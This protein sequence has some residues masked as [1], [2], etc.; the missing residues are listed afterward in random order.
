MSEQPIHPESWQLTPADAAAI[1][2]LVEAGFD[3]RRVGADVQPRALHASGLFS[4]LDA[5]RVDRGIVD[6]TL[7]RLVR[8]SAPEPDPVLSADD[9]EAL[10]AW[11]S[12]GYRAAKV[13][14]SLRAR[15]E[16]LDAMAAI[17][18]AP[19][20]GAAASSDLVSRT[21]DRILREREAAPAPIPISRGVPGRFR[22]SDLVSVAAMLLIAASVLWPVMTAVRN[23]SIRR[24]CAA[25]LGAVAS[26]MGMYAGDNADSLPVATAG[27]DGSWWDVGRG[28]RRS[29]SANLFTL[30]K[31]RYTNIGTLACPGNANAA[32]A[33]DCS[34]A[35]DWPNLNAVS[36]S[37]QIMGGQAHPRWQTGGPSPVLS[38]R[39]PVVLRAVRGEAIFPN[40]N[41]PNHGGRGQGVL[42]T[43]GSLIWMQTPVYHGDNIWL[44]SIVEAAIDR[45][46]EQLSRTGRL[47]SFTLRGDELPAK[48][49]VFL[50]P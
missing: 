23:H 20:S 48:Q 25:N 39:S 28:A 29:N 34:K 17:V 13:P 22:F 44:P 30:A 7:A 6:I 41:S 35:C 5:G 8:A 45:A 24:D 2:A 3:P 19:A 12:A 32:C 18:S 33:I 15:A 43:D 27:F 26:A 49:D 10:D 40:E 21:F 31:E 1:D 11:V 16:R 9:E 36:Y 47:E 38:D 46:R 50:G 37:Y 4:L 14:A 42:R